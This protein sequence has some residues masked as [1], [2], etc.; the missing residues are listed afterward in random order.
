[1]GI[2]DSI[3]NAIFGKAAAAEQ[4]GDNPADLNNKII[5]ATSGEV[6]LGEPAGT[7]DVSAVLEAAIAAKG[8]KLNW[9]T[10]IVDLMK[11]LDL[12]SSLGARKELAAELGFSGDSS[13]SAAMNK[14]LHKA[15]MQKL[16]EN[17]GKVP[18]ELRD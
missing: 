5:V 18:E 16:A 12:D 13:D 1:M 3:K 4:L 10:S 8:Q 17:G 6:T 7:V 15:L 9:K 2:F 14:W 11:A